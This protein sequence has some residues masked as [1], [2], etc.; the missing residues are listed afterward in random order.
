MAI[1][2]LIAPIFFSI[3]GILFLREAIVIVK[4][5][6]YIHNGIRPHLVKL[7]C[8]DIWRW[9]FFYSEQNFIKKLILS[10]LNRSRWLVFVVPS[11]IS[12]TF[13]HVVQKQPVI[14]YEGILYMISVLVIVL[15]FVLALSERFFVKIS[16]K[17]DT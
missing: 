16:L 11:V 4:I 12:L 3:L 2:F 13:Y 14:K 1:V 5:G 7:T 9:E 10:A 15:N 6:D 17:S 8:D